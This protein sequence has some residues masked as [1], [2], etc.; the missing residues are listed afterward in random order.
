MKKERNEYRKLPEM[1]TRV[2][3]SVGARVGSE[4]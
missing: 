2:I 1:A 4:T 3:Q